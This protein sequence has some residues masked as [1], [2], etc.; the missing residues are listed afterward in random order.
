MKTKLLPFLVSMIFIA[1][2]I[3]PCFGQL[4]GVKSIP[5]DYPSIA[6]AVA[7]LNTGGPGTGGVTFNI[8]ANYTETITTFISLTATGTAANPVV[9]QK[10]PSTTGANP[11][12][13]AYT[14]GVGT[15]STAVQDGIWRF[16]GSDYITINGIDVRDNPSNAN[17]ATMEYGYALY[18]ASATDGCQHVTIQNCTITL[19][20]ANNA[21]A[22]GPMTEGSAGIILMYALATSATTT[23]SPTTSLGSNSYNRF[24]SNTI[25]NCN[26]GISM[27]G[28]QPATDYTLADNNNDIGGSSAATGNTIINFGGA[29]GATNPAAGIRTLA[30]YGLNVS[31][32]TINSNNGGGINHANILRGIYINTAK[33]ANAVISFNS[34]TIKGGGTTQQLTGIE[35]ASGSTA[36]A[37]TVAIN[38]NTITNCTYTTATTGNF[39]GI[40]NSA[41]P[42]AVTINTNTISNN[43]SAATSA[44][45]TTGLFYEI[46]NGG[47]ASAVTI[48]NNILTGNSTGTS[49]GA[50]MA[51]YNSGST[52]VLNINSNTLAGDSTATVTGLHYSIYNYGSIVTTVN[53]NANNIGTA[54]LP[55]IKFTAAN[56][57]AQ[58]FIYNYKGTTTSALSISNNNFY[59]IVYVIAT[60]AANTYIL[61][62]YATRSQAINNNTFNNM[63][64]NSLGS[65]TF[66]SNSVIVSATGT[67]NVNNNAIVG[68]YAKTGGGTG[69]VTLFTSSVASVAGSVI[70][71][72]NNN[73]SNITLT[74]ATIMAGWVN[75]DA[76]AS[77]KTIQNNTFSNWAVGTGYVNGMNVN[78]TGTNNAVTGN[79]INNI[80]GAAAI[81]GITTAAGNDKIYL[82]TINTLSTTGVAAVT[83]ILI[84]AGTNKNIYANKIYDLSVNNATA[85]VNGIMVS[86]TTVATVNIFNNL[87]G[88]L[89]SSIANSSTDVIRGIN[90]TATAVN[91]TLNVYYN[92]VYLNATSSGAA[93]STTGI[94]HVTSTTATTGTLNLRN[95]IITNTSTPN[96]SGLSVAYRISSTALANY[97]ATSN[98]NLFYAGIP[99]ATKLLFYDGTDIVQFIANYRILVTSRDSLSV[100][101]DLI[102]TSKF[103]SVSGSSASFLHLDPS[104][105]T[106]AESGAANIAGYTT[107]YDA[108]IRQGNTGY[109]GTG[110]APDIGADEFAG[111]ATAMLTGSFNVG[112]GQTFTSL[113]GAGGLFAGINSLGLSGNLTVNITSDLTE[114]GTNVLYQWA[115]KGAGNYSLTI[116]PDASTARLISGNVL[117]GMIRFSGAKRVTIDGS[118]G[119]TS[120]YLTFRNTNTPVATGTAFTFINAATGITIKY[121]NIEAAANATSGVIFFSTSALAGGN[122]NNIIRNCSINGTVSAVSGNICIYSAGSVGNENTN[123]TFTNNKIFNYRDRALDI[124]ATG[125]KSW[126]IT[127]NSCYNGDVS[128]TSYTAA[129]TLHGIRVLGGS[130]YTITGNYIGGNAAL[131]AG[132]VASYS[133]A[134]ILS[135]QGILLT[136]SSATPVSLIT[137]NTVANMSFNVVPTVAYVCQCF[138]R[139]RNKWFG[140]KYRR[141]ACRRRK[142]DWFKYGKRIGCGNNYH[143]F[144]HLS[145]TLIKGI[146][147]NSTGGLVMGN[148]VGGIDVSN[149]GTSPGASTALRYIH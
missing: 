52:P 32:N 70:N 114:D 38:N 4:T 132:T 46:N 137:G 116:Q 144:K 44:V 42:A 119:S 90:L 99:S 124:T 98:N 64:V 75:T 12:I 28:Y 17:P 125:S 96:G 22:A 131:A 29:T 24:Y 62:G 110:T 87:I 112:T 139:D 105:A 40:Y 86:G 23:L 113:T 35:N 55:A 1:A 16:I 93:F 5:G 97:G 145:L 56:A 73:F 11:L 2:G 36:A 146:N 59:N 43:T 149:V 41:T 127:G 65:A 133:S 6:S 50:F 27:I 128:G 140:H 54:V 39:Y 60:T 45:S 121:C 53:I 67:Q 104:K 20:R 77:T 37:N 72:N 108:Q 129:A 61:N 8:A 147:C 9:F 71:N 83:G 47:A 69:T 33:S 58:S 142:Y 51:I 130:G 118:N 138:Y 49:I 102:G 148:Q 134:G 94:Y 18:K 25:Q 63:N 14:T 123:N 95:N 126:I 111:T 84:T 30:Q 143:Q 120:N 7:A 80:T 66:I 106:Q 31:Y 81:T 26:I 141:P 107:D 101:E 74:G 92:T 21:S 100:T 122:S 117:A 79:F 91:S 34:I 76:G 109:S 68:S 10:D 89:R 15:P 135:F 13:T 136:T 85:T 82:N 88:D 103:L 48:N 78:I 57:V 19:N 115:E 3:S